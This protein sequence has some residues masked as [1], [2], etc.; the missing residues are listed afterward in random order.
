MIKEWQH[1]TYDYSTGNGIMTNTM[2]IEYET[3][4]YGQGAVGGATPSNTVVGFADPAHYDTVKSALARPGATATVFG[5]G[6]LIDA[7]EGTFDDLALL[8]D[9]KGGVQNVLGAIQQAGTAYQ[10]FKGRNLRSIVD[11]EARQASKDILRAQLPGAVRVAVN[12]ANGMLFP[13]PPVR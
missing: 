11:Q 2:V 5:Q 12:T 10:T 8:A 9:G 4:K 3:V 13:K 1:D 6:G 7:I